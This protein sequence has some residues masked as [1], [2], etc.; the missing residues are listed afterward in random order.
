MIVITMMIKTKMMVTSESQNLCHSLAFSSFLLLIFIPEQ[1]SVIKVH[2]SVSNFQ[3]WSKHNFQFQFQNQRPPMHE[4]ISWHQMADM[5]LW[6]PV[7]LNCSLNDDSCKWNEKTEDEP[8]V[9]HL[10][11][12]GRRKSLNLARED[13]RH[14]QHDGQVHRDIL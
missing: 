3:P 10:S 9:N 8:S 11:V 5:W 14:H 2:L 13:G 4:W 12:R 1:W 6:T 7:T